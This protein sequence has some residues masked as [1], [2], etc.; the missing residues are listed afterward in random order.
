MSPEDAANDSATLPPRITAPG[1]SDAAISNGTGK[2]WDEWFTLLDAWGAASR[3][4]AG[5]GTDDDR[6]A[7]CGTEPYEVTV[8]DGIVTSVP[9]SLATGFSPRACARPSCFTTA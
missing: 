7:P 6:A 8:H 2:S 3:L 1:M 9:T 5:C 4:R